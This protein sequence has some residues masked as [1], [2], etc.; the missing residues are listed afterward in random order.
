MS[1]IQEVDTKEDE[2]VIRANVNKK[3]SKELN[4]GELVFD[5]PPDYDPP[6]EPGLANSNVII[7]SYY[8]LHNRP[9]KITSINY[10]EIIKDDIRNL[11]PLNKYQLEFVKNLSHEQKNELLE[12][13]NSC[14]ETVSGLL[15]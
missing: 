2:Y 11:R 9:S 10:Y 13:F 5:D 6:A 14:L 4:L 7:P 12:I 3:L 15:L 8:H 1:N